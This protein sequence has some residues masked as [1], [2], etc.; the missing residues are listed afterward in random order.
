M[1]GFF[2]LVRKLQRGAPY[3]VLTLWEHL[4]CFLCTPLLLEET[5]TR[6]LHALVRWAAEDRRG[7]PVLHLHP[8]TA[9]GAFQRH[10]GDYLM[11]CKGLSRIGNIHTRAFFRR[12]EDAETYFART[13]SGTSRKALRRHRRQLE[14]LGDLEFR[15]LAPEEPEQAWIEWFL[16]LE[17]SGWKGRNN[18]ALA[19]NPTERD[20]FTE[21]TRA[22]RQ[23]GKVEMRGLFLDG[24]P[25]AMHCD[26]RAGRGAF[27]FKM[28]FDESFARYS[29]GV[30]LEMETISS[31]HETH[32]TM[33]WGSC[34][35]PDAA[36]PNRL[37]KERRCLQGVLISCGSRW[38]DLIV[39]LEPLQRIARSLPQRMRRLMR[40]RSVPIPLSFA[41]T[42][43]ARHR[44]YA[45]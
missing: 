8:I 42:G 10:L 16:E 9:D 30:L 19:S 28:A 14:S 11:G 6:P 23:R 22:A 27:G 45:C 26:F 44:S 43:S 3:A 2:P 41:R 24:R 21:I 36:L 5:G 33:W 31:Y 39:A 32:R 12:D 35:A 20:F 18:T 17:A 7:A 37:Y 40:V 29:P 34:S 25:I 4:H 13:I 1:C 38:G 15:T